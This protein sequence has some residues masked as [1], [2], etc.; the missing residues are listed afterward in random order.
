MERE[1]LASGEG[2]SLYGV[3]GHAPPPPE[4]VQIWKP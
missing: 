4:N 2:A 3:G 1:S